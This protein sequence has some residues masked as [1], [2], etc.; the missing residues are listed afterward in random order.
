MKYVKNI[1][2]NQSMKSVQNWIWLS[3]NISPEIIISKSK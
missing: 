1:F 2:P 3:L